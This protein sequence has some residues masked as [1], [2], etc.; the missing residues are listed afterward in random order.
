MG[1]V[2]GGGDEGI[3][4]FGAGNGSAAEQRPARVQVGRRIDEL[5]DAIDVAAQL[6]EGRVDLSD[7]VDQ[8]PPPF[9]L[10]DEAIRIGAVGIGQSHQIGIEA[11]LAADHRVLEDVVIVDDRIDRGIGE[12]I[13]GAEQGAGLIEPHAGVVPIVQALEVG[14]R[15]AVGLELAVQT[16]IAAEGVV[17]LGDRIPAIG[18]IGVERELALGLDAAAEIT[19][20]RRVEGAVVPYAGEVDAIGAARQALPP[21]SLQQGARLRGVHRREGEVVSVGQREVIGNRHRRAEAIGL[22]IHR[23]QEA[24]LSLHRRIGALEIGHPHHRHA[25][26]I[27]E[28]IAIGDGR[29]ILAVDDRLRANAPGRRLVGVVGAGFARREPAVMEHGDVA[30]LARGGLGDDPGVVLGDDAQGIDEAVAEVVGERHLVRGD[31]RAFGVLDAHIA[32]RRE[33]VGA[34]VIDHLIGEQGV[35]A[36]VDLDVAFGRDL[37]VLVVVDHLV[38]LKQHGLARVHFRRLQDGAEIGL[39]LRLRSCIARAP[40]CSRRSRRNRRSSRRSGAT[41]RRRGA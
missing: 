19:V 14:L 24:G 23:H 17:R 29:L 32:L 34:A 30:G 18:P 39:L 11:E 33:R 16:V 20:D 8:L 25:E 13:L 38:G 12:G 6:G 2:A 36:V 41:P 28:T 21:R 27:K 26:E 3:A 5:V 7:A 22:L 9:G 31:D 37:V 1:D 4:I 40:G 15:D 10:Q 35:V